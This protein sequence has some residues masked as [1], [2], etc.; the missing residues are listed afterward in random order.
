MKPPLAFTAASFLLAPAIPA[1]AQQGASPDPQIK[2]VLDVLD[3]LG[4]KPIATL[5]P[6][7]ARKQPSPTDPVAALMKMQAKE[8]P[9]PVG[10]VAN[11]KG[12]SNDAE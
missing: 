9:E 3:A 12:I 11:P 1:P 2:A 7:V 8:W 5:S 4:G 6:E 10:D